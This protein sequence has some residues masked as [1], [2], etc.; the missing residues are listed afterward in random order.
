MTSLPKLPKQE[1][2]VCQGWNWTLEDIKTYNLPVNV[3]AI[4]TTDDGTTRLHIHLKKGRTSPAVGLGVN[5]TVTVDWG[6]GTTPDTLTGT[7]TSTPVFTPNHEYASDGDY[8]IKLTVDGTAVFLGQT[9]KTCLVSIGSAMSSSTNGVYAS[10]LRRIDIGNG[11]G[12]IGSYAFGSCYNLRFISIPNGITT[13]GGSAGESAFIK[14]GLKFVGVPNGA[15]AVRGQSTYGAFRECYGLELVSLPNSVTGTSTNMCTSC[16][17]LKSMSIPNSITS[18]GTE[19]C[20]GCRGLTHVSI[21]DSITA[22]GTRAFS[23]CVTLASM[24]FP[25]S[26]E[27][28]NSAAFQYCYSVRYYDFSQHT[29]VPTLASTD[30]FSGIPADC[31]IRVPAA[32]YDEWIAATN[33][34]TYADKIVA[35]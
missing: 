5:G 20:N 9:S 35:V 6:D 18:I 28:I 11:I 32:L 15:T 19:M 13:I 4:Y 24:R 21:P 23:S 14:S 12:S 8:I 10:S 31:E 17:C 1:G 22:I 16:Y 2:L 29:S 7:S 3:C 33:W 34:A 25:S 27:S 26:V 30:A